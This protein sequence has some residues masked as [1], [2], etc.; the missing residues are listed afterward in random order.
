[1]L[2]G[3]LREPPVPVVDAP[4]IPTVVIEAE[5]GEVPGLALFDHHGP[6]ELNQLVGVE[7]AG[8]NGE[9]R[10]AVAMDLVGADDD[11]VLEALV[12][13]GAQESEHLAQVDNETGPLAEGLSSM[14]GH[15]IDQADHG[16]VFVVDPQ[17]VSPL[18]EF[19]EVFGGRVHHDKESLVSIRRTIE[20]AVDMPGHVLLVNDLV[21]EAKPEVVDG[22][23]L[24]FCEHE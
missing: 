12:N 21:H 5:G 20:L 22:E 11:V 13:G 19:A 16:P 15:P 7:R 17:V 8:L 1:M 10:D 3:E 2:D 9:G 24:F 23:P 4:H 6:A 14:G 18:E